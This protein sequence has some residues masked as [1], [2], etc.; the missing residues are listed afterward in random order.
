MIDMGAVLGGR[1][2]VGRHSHVGA[3]AVLAGVV[4]PPSAKPGARS[5]TTCSSAQTRS[6][7]RARTVGNGAVVAAG[8]VVTQDVPEN[9]VV[10]GVPARIVKM[11]DDQDRGQDGARRRPAGAVSGMSPPPLPPWFCKEMEGLLT[12]AILRNFNMPKKDWKQPFWI[13]RGSRTSGLPEQKQGKQ[14]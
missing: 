6:S 5:A 10:A 14:L 12:R 2:I 11:K 1:A 3:G 9:A 13:S 8:A 4:E 7:S